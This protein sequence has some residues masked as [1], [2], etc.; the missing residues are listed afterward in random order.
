MKNYISDIIDEIGVTKY[1]WIIFFLIGFAHLL[2]GFDNM[3]VPYTMPQIAKEWAL[4][5]VQTGSLVSWGFVG[6]ILGAIIAGSLSDRIGRKKMMIAACLVYSIFS[7]LTYFAPNFTTYAILRI[8]SG[9]GYGAAI[10][11]GVT[12]MS[13]FAPTK[14]RG[15][16]VTALSGFLIGGWILA[17]I[18]AMAVVPAMGWRLIYLIGILPC[19]YAIVLAKY[20]PESPRWL[21][22]KG[23][24]TEVVKVIQSIERSA[25]GVAREW[26]ADSLIAPSPP[27][28]VGIRA[29]FS[30]E[31]FSAT[32]NLSILYFCGLM[33]A[34]GVSGWLPTLLLQ[35]GYSVVK[36]YSFSISQNFA[37]II[38]CFLSG[39]IADKIGRRKS[40]A[41]FFALTAVFLFLLGN[42]VNQW[43]IVVFGMLVGATM[44]FSMAG[45]QPLLVET[46][47]T[48]FRNSG[49]SWAQGLGRVGSIVG[50][51]VAGYVQ[52]IGL[53]FNATLS[54]F[55]APAVISVIIIILFIKETKGKRI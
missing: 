40:E 42:A 1:T 18:I 22:S 3:V 11:V 9:V 29:L 49:V 48:E 34:Y 14:N 12:L 5:K 31:Y 24:E 19:L 6:S 2:D 20:M 35:K 30:K 13:E 37:G 26:D 50:P 44:N 21:L 54:V 53:G 46:Y 10:P 32:L 38:G 45:L 16:F 17:G 27:Q 39:F 51:L 28:T 4:T 41:Y 52:Q 55:A 36:S 47:P 8:L 43:A 7:G 33:I 15:F 23:R 25:K